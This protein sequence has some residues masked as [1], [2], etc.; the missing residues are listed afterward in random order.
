VIS[1]A[2]T[3][4][5]GTRADLPD[6][7]TMSYEPVV[8][9]TAAADAETADAAVVGLERLS[10]LTDA[11]RHDLTCAGHPSRPAAS[12]SCAVVRVTSIVVVGVSTEAFEIVI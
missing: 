11:A 5:L 8:A 12:T 10:E 7:L 4:W 6:E 9:A 1:H 3:A 2:A